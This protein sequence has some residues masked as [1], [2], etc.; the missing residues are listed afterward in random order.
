MQLLN[1]WQLA[2]NHLIQKNEMETETQCGRKEFAHKAV[3]ANAD[4]INFVGCAPI[5]SIILSAIQ[6]YAMKHPVGSPAP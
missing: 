3:R 4:T 5:P 6:G 2:V 1:P